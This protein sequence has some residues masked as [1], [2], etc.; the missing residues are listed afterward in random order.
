MISQHTS[1]KLL[2]AGKTGVHLAERGLQVYHTV[3]GA[4]AAGS[5]LY[6]AVSPYVMGAAAV[7][8]LP[9]ALISTWVAWSVMVTSL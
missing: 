6:S 8:A 9:L 2:E 5:A 1:R 3:R 4:V 7:R